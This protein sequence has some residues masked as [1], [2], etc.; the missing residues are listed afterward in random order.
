MTGANGRRNEIDNEMPIFIAARD[1]SPV[2]GRAAQSEELIKS[3]KA[4]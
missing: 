2:N 4:N 1:F 3:E